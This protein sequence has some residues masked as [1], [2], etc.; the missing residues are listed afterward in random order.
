MKKY[1]RA[2][3]I[4]A[5]C[6]LAYMITYISRQSLSMAT[7]VIKELKI[8]DAAQIG[9]L[10]S[11]FS[12][13]YSCGRLINGRLGDKI[14]P[15]I[16]VPA[17]LM[18]IAI[19]NFSFGFFPPF[20]VLALLWAINAFGQSTMWG[21]MLVVL[22]NTLP[23]E[24]LS[25]GMSVYT[26]V[27]SVGTI[28]G[29]FAATGAINIKGVSYAFF[30]PGVLGAVF[31]IV[32]AFAY[33]GVKLKAEE[34]S[35]KAEIFSLKD[36]LRE[37]ELISSIFPAFCH[38][39]IKDNITLWMSVYFVERFAVNLESSAL[40][41]F[42]IPAFGLVGRLLYPSVYTLCKNNF[43]KVNVLAFL[44][45]G[46]FSLPLVFIRSSADFSVLLPVI[47]AFCLGMINLCINILNH[48]LLAVFPLEFSKNGA[49][50]TISGILDFFAY[51]GAAA[52]S[53]FYG[54][55]LKY[56]DYSYMYLSWVIVCVAAGVFTLCKVMKAKGKKQNF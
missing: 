45:C 33:K 55:L 28:A 13:V 51:F 12:A 21:C 56:T 8:M 11:I 17:G 31:A 37:K 42:L 5:V 50:S 16:L 46:A 53:L 38:G 27:L 18:L 47:A 44:T 36:I 49:T 40:F 7:S 9:I 6:Y 29:I 23:P 26:T 4:F 3:L 35:A 22:G 24:K 41:I 39:V 14:P 48:S 43:K 15:R 30:V 20:P 10:G 32:T 34:K 19:S 54:F 25:R 2:I 52:S 1:S